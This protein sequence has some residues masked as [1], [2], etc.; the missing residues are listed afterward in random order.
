MSSSKIVPHQ[1]NSAH[2]E[3]TTNVSSPRPTAYEGDAWPARLGPLT[4]NQ[5]APAALSPHATMADLAHQEEASHG[6]QRRP[7]KF[8]CPQDNCGRRKTAFTTAYR[9]KSWFYLGPRFIPT[10]N[11]GSTAHINRYH[12]SPSLQKRYECGLGTCGYT[13]LYSTDLPRHRKT[14][15]QRSVNFAVDLH[16]T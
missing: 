6:Q 8:L 11:T 7:P 1:N 13:T 5:M 2:E 15:K 14:C 16:S 9:L 12:T 10:T 4:R 3:S